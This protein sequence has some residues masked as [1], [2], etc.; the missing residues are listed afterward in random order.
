MTEPRW[1]T[2]GLGTF[3][4]L[5]FYRNCCQEGD[6][7]ALVTHIRDETHRR[8]SWEQEFRLQ[9]PAFRMCL[10][11]FRSRATDVSSP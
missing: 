3:C 11:E 7:A 10:P 8:T 5:R 1:L 6:E 2:G 9:T 4:G